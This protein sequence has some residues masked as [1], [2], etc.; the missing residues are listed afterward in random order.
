MPVGDVV[1]AIDLIEVLKKKHGMKG[2]KRMVMYIEACESGSI[3]NGLLPDDVSVYTTTASKPDELSWACYCPGEDDSDDDDQSHQSAPPG[4]PDYYATCLGDFYS[5]KKRT[6][7]SHVMQYGDISLNN[8]FRSLFMGPNYPDHNLS[9]STQT[10]PYSSS[11]G[12][13]VQKVP[14]GSLEQLEA[15]KRL[16]DELLYREEVDRKIGKIAKLL[17]SE[18]DVAAGLSSVVLP[19]REGEPL[20]DDWECFKSMLRTYEERCGALTHYGRKYSRVMANMCNAGINQDQ[21]TWASTK[22]CS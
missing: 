21:L 22:A 4:S 20:V 19:E 6:N 12:G 17:L 14:D 11:S 2:Y 3:V 16:R 8:L 15:E 7:T 9:A 10:K 1:Y 18:K 13:L 5:V